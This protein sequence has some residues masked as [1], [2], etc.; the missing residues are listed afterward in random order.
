MNAQCV[1]SPLKMAR[2][3]ANSAVGAKTAGWIGYP[4]NQSLGTNG[5]IIYD[6]ENIHNAQ[7]FARECYA[8]LY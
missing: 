6:T 5:T 7:R 8:Q 3:T 2:I 1:G 4:E